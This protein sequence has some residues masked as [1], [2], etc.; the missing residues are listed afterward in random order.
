[1]NQKPL[2]CSG[3]GIS[4]DGAFARQSIDVRRFH[5]WMADAAQLVEPQVVHEDE[6]DVGT[7]RLLSGCGTGEDGECQ[8]G[9][10]AENCASSHGWARVRN[11][12]ELG[13][14]P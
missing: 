3:E 9:G 6:D 2:W 13:W 12:V 4:K 5:E 11:A 14:R 1:M 8:E 7:G 10:Q